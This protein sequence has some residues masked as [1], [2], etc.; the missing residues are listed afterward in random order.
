MENQ[1]AIDDRRRSWTISVLIHAG[2]FLLGIIPFMV[3][4]APQEFIQAITIDFQDNASKASGSAASS[5]SANRSP[6]PQMEVQSVNSITPSQPLPKP[7]LAQPVI[8]SPQPDVRIV[9]SRTAYFDEEITTEQESSGDASDEPQPLDGNGTAEDGD[10]F[11]SSNWPGE[12]FGEMDGLADSAEEDGLFDGKW[13]GELDGDEGKTLGIGQDGQGNIW[14]DFAGDGLFNRKV[15]QRANVAS[16]AEE[17]G[18]VVVNLCVNR[19]GKV[20]YTE[21]DPAK[22]TIANPSIVAKAELCAANYIFDQDLT[23]DPEQCG[24]LTFIFKIEK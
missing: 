2:L 13:P 16:L 15:I 5:A 22:S 20:V 17:N 7:T 18:K 19:Q 9:E 14:G 8:T 1:L 3:E 6:R 21:I 11:A 10:P 24:K 4:K 23:A 12:D